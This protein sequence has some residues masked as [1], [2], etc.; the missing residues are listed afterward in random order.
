MKYARIPTRKGRVFRISF[1]PDLNHPAWEDDGPLPTPQTLPDAFYRSFNPTF[2]VPDKVS[3]RRRPPTNLSR[4]ALGKR[5]YRAGLRG[6]EL[7]RVATAILAGPSSPE[8]SIGLTVMGWNLKALLREFGRRV[9]R[10]VTR[11]F[12]KLHILVD[13]AWY[14][15]QAPE[16]SG[17]IQSAFTLARKHGGTSITVLQEPV[18]V[19]PCHNGAGSNV[20]EGPC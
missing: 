15:L 3:G 12:R 20:V 18:S 1:L 13:E 14:L 17:M 4:R 7:K 19:G 8:D 16:V 11:F 5:L 9:T 6:A 2:P 10:A